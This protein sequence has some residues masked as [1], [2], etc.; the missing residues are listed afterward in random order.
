[1]PVSKIEVVFKSGCTEAIRYAYAVGGGNVSGDTVASLAENRIGTS[2]KE[3]Y[4]AVREV[5]SGFRKKKI[6]YEVKIRLEA[7]AAKD[8]VIGV[9]VFDPEFM[10][11]VEQPNLDGFPFGN[12]C[13]QE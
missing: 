10:L 4:C 13:L 2:V 9:C 7:P 6:A 11:F 12:D 8:G 3:M 1:M 5:E